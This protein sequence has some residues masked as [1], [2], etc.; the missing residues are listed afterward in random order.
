MVEGAGQTAGK[1]GEEVQE[2]Q[3]WGTFRR[4]EW[5][6]KGEAVEV[7]RAGGVNWF[8]VEALGSKEYFMERPGC[9]YMI[10]ACAE[11][12]SRCAEERWI[13]GGKSLRV[14]MR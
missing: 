6:N 1:E 13:R 2:V 9:E 3:V 10:P 11:R 7:R 5:S 8:A 12:R 14:A 4:N